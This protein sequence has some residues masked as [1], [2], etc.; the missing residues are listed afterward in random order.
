MKSYNKVTM[1][2]FLFAGLILFVVVLIGF[3]YVYFLQSDIEKIGY[4]RVFNNKNQ[5]LL[6]GREFEGRLVDGRGDDKLL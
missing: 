3:V 4:V 2:K 1:K 6:Y 5:D